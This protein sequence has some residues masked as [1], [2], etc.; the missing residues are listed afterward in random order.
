M[1]YDTYKTTKKLIVLLL[2]KPH[3]L[4]YQ[5]KKKFPVLTNELINRPACSFQYTH[6]HTHTQTVHRDRIVS[7]VG[8]TTGYSATVWS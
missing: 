4:L 1:R 3:H 2:I 7:M 5:V 8:A 6:T